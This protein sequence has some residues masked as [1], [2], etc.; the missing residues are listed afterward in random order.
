MNKYRM[1]ICQILETRIKYIKAQTLLDNMTGEIRKDERNKVLDEV[2][3]II[4]KHKRIDE[5]IWQGYGTFY[6]LDM[7]C[8]DAIKQLKE[9]E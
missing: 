9:G 3:E 8:I 4:E 1:R 7:K 6:K 5:S 2:L